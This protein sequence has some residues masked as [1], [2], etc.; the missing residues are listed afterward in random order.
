MRQR[1][2]IHKKMKYTYF[3]FEPFDQEKRTFFENNS[4]IIVNAESGFV[5]CFC[6]NIMRMRTN[7]IDSHSCVNIMIE[8]KQVPEID[9]VI[10]SL[11]QKTFES[12][13]NLSFILV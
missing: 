1:S 9:F 3:I 13:L 12:S 6:V 5:Y 10:A 8:R 2:K 11:R 7:D 4:L